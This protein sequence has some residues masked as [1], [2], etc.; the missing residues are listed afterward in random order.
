MENVILKR[1]KLRNLANLFNRH[2]IR[3]VWGDISSLRSLAWEEMRKPSPHFEKWRVPKELVDSVSCKWDSD[4][5]EEARVEYFTDSC[6]FG[7]LR[8]AEALFEGD[9]TIIKMVDTSGK[10]GLMTS[11]I[12]ESHSISRWLLT[13]PGLDLNI[14]SE[15]SANLTAIQWASEVDTPLDI[16]I[17]LAKMSTW[18]TLN[19][20][21]NVN[22]TALDMAIE[23]DQTSIAIYLSWL[24]T[25]CK[26][27]N[28]KYREVT[29]D[30]WLEAGCEQDAALWAVAANDTR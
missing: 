14:K 20:K 26:K 8:W 18:E 29:L 1:E 28:K 6:W 19:L 27:E 23:E 30:T 5:E 4:F 10:T 15:D 11:L 9:P 7:N 3:K 2:K 16:I 12:Y 25:N 17:K 24:G 22:C 13:L 21:S